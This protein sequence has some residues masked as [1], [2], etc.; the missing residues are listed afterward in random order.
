MTYPCKFD[1]VTLEFYLSH[2]H[3]AICNSCFLSHVGAFWG[4]FLGPIFIIML[5]NAFIFIR[6]IIVMV[7]HTK[8]TAARLNKPVSNKTIIRLMISIGGVMFLFGL[9]WLFAVLTFSVTGLRETFQILFVVFNSFQGLFIFLF[10]CVLNKE[11]LESWREVLTC[12]RYQS[13]LLHP[14]PAKIVA[15]R[16]YQANT[17]STGFSSSSGGKYNSETLKSGY[18]SSTLS[19]QNIARAPNLSTEDMQKTAKIPK[20]DRLSTKTATS[21]GASAQLTTNTI[22]INQNKRDSDGEETA[23]R[24]ARKKSVVKIEVVEEVGNGENL[25]EESSKNTTK[26]HTV[27]IEVVE[28]A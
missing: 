26:K 19:I 1:S 27:R 3:S 25:E 14:T 28:E 22:I 11:V 9:T 21:D 18:N 13:K 15:V 16:K 12:G 20:L 17:N 7:R 23:K 5:F 4:A 8:D 2:A 10:V 6:V 24:Q